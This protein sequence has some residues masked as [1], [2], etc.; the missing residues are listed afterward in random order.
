MQF[1]GERYMPCAET[2]NQAI[3]REHWQR[4]FF[5]QNFI[6]ENHQILDIASGE[7][8]GSNFLAQKAQ[9]VIGID[10][11][12]EAVSYAREKYIRDNLEFRVGNVAQIPLSSDSMD[13]IVSFETIEHVDS[14]TQVKFLTECKRILHKDGYLIVS[15]PNKPI[16]SELAYKLWGFKNPYHKKEYEINEFEE[17]LHRYFQYVM[18]FYQRTETNLV[19]SQSHPQQLKVIWGGKKNVEDT[20]NI[21]AICSDILISQKVEDLIILDID[22]TYI[23]TESELSRQIRANQDKHLEN[24]LQKYNELIAANEIEFE[25]YRKIVEQQQAA[26]KEYEKALSDQNIALEKY[27]QQGEYVVRLQN[28]LEEYKKMLGR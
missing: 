25:K 19:L 22:N 28:E 4:Y 17:F 2:K 23:K 11:S 8:Y 26:L 24:E 7:G 6:S 9:K 15:C 21:I 20:Q 13:G 14:S 10:I 18:L 27:R 12:N 3:E 1:T 5:A 16:A